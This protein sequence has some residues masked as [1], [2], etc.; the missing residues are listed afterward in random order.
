MVHYAGVTHSRFDFVCW[1]KSHATR[2]V[3]LH[4]NSELPV[5]NKV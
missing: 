5:T 3:L 2:D 1:S 4:Q